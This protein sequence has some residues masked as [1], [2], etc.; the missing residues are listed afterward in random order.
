MMVFFLP[1]FFSQT[2]CIYV[3]RKTTNSK[4]THCRTISF[5]KHK[6]CDKR[7]KLSRFRCEIPTAYGSIKL[8]SET[9]MST[10]LLQVPFQIMLLQ[11]LK[12]HEQAAVTDT[13]TGNA[14]MYKKQRALLGLKTFL[15]HLC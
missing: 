12:L 11:R 3:S 10:C 8:N 15:A 7:C 14:Y 1:S 4:F 9:K 13:Q 2:R 6:L 5:L